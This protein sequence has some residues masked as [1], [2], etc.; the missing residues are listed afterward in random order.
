MSVS[1]IR[2]L[3]LTGLLILIGVAL[4][5]ANPHV[6]QARQPDDDV[7]GSL[8]DRNRGHRF[9]PGPD[10][11]RHRHVDRRGHRHHLDDLRQLH[12][13][14]AAPCIHLHPH[15]AR[16]RLRDRLGQRLLHH[17]F[18]APG[19]HCHSGHA[20]HSGWAGADH[21]GQGRTR[22]REERVH[23]GRGFSILWRNC[24]TGLYRDHRV[25]H[26]GHRHAVLYEAHAR[27]ARTS[28]RRAP[29][30]P[31]HDFQASTWTAR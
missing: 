13:L 4:S 17:P 1:A 7:S 5:I 19:V 23:R 9:H 21:R 15:G 26:S 31:P 28:T 6:P 27:P 14:Y 25:H 8:T 12:F 18:Q 2:R 29:T 16:C 24:R 30:P 20:R 10:H 3:I 22:L 11:R